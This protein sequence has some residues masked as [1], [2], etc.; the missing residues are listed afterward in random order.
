MPKI[1]IIDDER[2]TREGL[3]EALC[4]DYDVAIAEDGIKGMAYLKANPVDI[5]LTDLRMPGLDGMEFTREV[6]SWPNHPLIIMLT[7]YGS[8]QTA[9]E[10]LKIGAYDYIS[11]PVDLDNLE[12]MLKR[13]IEFLTRKRGGADQQTL[14]LPGIVWKSKGLQ[15]VMDQIR[16]VA[17]TRT[18]VLITGESG[19][20][21]ELAAQA[22]HKLSGR[23]S[24]PFIA[25]HCASLSENL[26]ESELFGHE[27]GA[28]TGASE[29]VQ[30]RFE[31]ADGGT[32]F[33]D[34]IGEISLPVQVKLLRV[35]ETQK[36]ERV[37][38]S[39]T[40]SVDVRVIAA[41]NRNLKAMVAEGTFREDLFYRLNVISIKLPPLRERRDD[42]PVIMDYYLKKCASE[43]GKHIDNFSPDAISMMSAYDW[44]GNVRE[45]RNAVERMVVFAEG[46]TLTMNDVPEDI[47]KA[48]LEQ[49]E[50]KDQPVVAESPHTSSEEAPVLDIHENE[51]A[52]IIKALEECGGNRSQAALKLKISRRTLHRKLNEYGI[53]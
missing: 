30:G 25:V 37:G 51:K 35:L 50:K 43:N 12:K 44:P 52:L 20:G 34:E 29:R 45:L 23:A 21:K 14:P 6:S 47:R 39:Q 28:F 11:K 32:L 48:L 38:G 4:D 18:T 1:L 49:F 3:Q 17:P 22:I 31:L 15:D 53:S 8:V 46:S 9:V 2:N 42:I 7:A 16:Q 26:L 5:V 13:G 36:F 19:T 10:A 33:L 24:K 27:K 40:L 41:T